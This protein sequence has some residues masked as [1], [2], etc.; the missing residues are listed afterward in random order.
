[1]KQ[2]LTGEY[3]S[4]GR[5]FAFALPEILPCQNIRRSKSEEGRDGYEESI[6]RAKRT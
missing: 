3:K 1:M 6:K 2:S 4:S 5:F